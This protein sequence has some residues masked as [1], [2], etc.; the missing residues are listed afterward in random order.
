MN[1]IVL[2]SPATICYDVGMV[3]QKDQIGIET[4]T[5]REKSDACLWLKRAIDKL[6]QD[7]DFNEFIKAYA[8]GVDAI[9][10]SVVCKELNKQT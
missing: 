8:I 2:Y 5:M 3:K 4:Y 6:T 7:D 1:Q 9:E 10:H